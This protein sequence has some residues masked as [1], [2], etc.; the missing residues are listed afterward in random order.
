MSNGMMTSREPVAWE[1]EWTSEG[2]VARRVGRVADLLVA[3]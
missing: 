3:E 1:R 2:V